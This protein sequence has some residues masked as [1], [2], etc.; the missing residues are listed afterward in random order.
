M[1]LSVAWGPK[2]IEKW[3]ANKPDIIL[4]YKLVE[5]NSDWVPARLVPMCF[6]GDMTFHLNNTLS[7]EPSSIYAEIEGRYRP[8]FHFFETEKDAKD[9]GFYIESPAP[10]RVIKCKIHKR[11][12]TC[13]GTQGGRYVIVAKAFTIIPSNDYER[14]LL[15]E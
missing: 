4:A 15:E 6:G 5:V 11:D 13:V 1:C 14:K 8:N 2:Q 3:L 9:W 10:T 7:F 12:V